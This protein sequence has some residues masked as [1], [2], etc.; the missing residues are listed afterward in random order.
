[1]M[2]VEVAPLVTDAFIHYSAN[3]R[4]VPG[5]AWGEAYTS[6]G[7]T[8]RSTTLLSDGQDDLM[9]ITAQMPIT[10]QPRTGPEFVV[11]PGD[12]VLSSQGREILMAFQGTGYAYCLRVSRRG[13]SQMVPRLSSAPVMNLP[14]QTPLLSLLWNYTRLLA[15][16]PLAG[17]NAQLM[18]GRQLQEMVALLVGG[19]P[20]LMDA[21]ASGTLAAARLKIA[22][23][24]IEAHLDDANLSLEAVAARQKVSPATCSGYSPAKVN[25]FPACCGAPVWIERAPCWKIRTMPGVRYFQSPSNA[26]LPKPPP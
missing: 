20:E 12:T 10:V 19:T 11:P 4:V 23:A 16:E 2:R 13:V 25:P 7:T 17:E 26:A 6:A 9:L 14:R 8:R 24:D 18:A 22:R 15:P 3:L 21:N 5:A 1:M